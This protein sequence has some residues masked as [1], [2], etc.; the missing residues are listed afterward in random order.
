MTPRKVVGCA[1]VL[2]FLGLWTA[3]LGP[4]EYVRLQRSREIE[5]INRLHLLSRALSEYQAVKGTFPPDERGLEGI[6]A[7]LPTSGHSPSSYRYSVPPEAPWHSPS[8]V[9]RVIT[10]LAARPWKVDELPSEDAW[11]HPL[12]YFAP[13]NPTGERLH[14]V[15]WSAGRDGC[16]QGWVSSGVTLHFDCDII[17]SDLVVVQRRDTCAV[18]EG[19]LDWS[20]YV[21]TVRSGFRALFRNCKDR[22]SPY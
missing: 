11:G 14:Y 3:W 17:L 21:D 22:S 12:K 1:V 4:K 2:L 15:L 16:F 18:F 20:Q 6:L 8:D 13:V 5:T 7:T 10:G 19:C 9:G